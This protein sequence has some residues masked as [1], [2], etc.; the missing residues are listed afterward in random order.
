MEGDKAKHLPIRFKRT[1][2]ICYCYCSQELELEA[3][4][5]VHGAALATHDHLVAGHHVS[6]A[7]VFFYD[8]NA[9]SSNKTAPVAAAASTLIFLAVAI[10]YNAQ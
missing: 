9:I 7:F 8:E 1:N 3:F 2:Q 4:H 6:A 5:L 10:V